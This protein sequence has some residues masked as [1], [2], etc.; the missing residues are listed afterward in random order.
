M[1]DVPIVDA[2]HHLCRLGM[3]YPWLSGAPT[4]RYHGDDTVLRHDYLVPDYLRDFGDLP[5]AAS[6][7][8][9]NGAGDPLEEARWIDGVCGRR[10]RPMVQVAKA[11]L[12]DPAAGEMLDA[13][14]DLLS[15]RGVRDIL[16][17]HPDPFYTHTARPHI[18][19]DPA[20]R[21]RFGELSGRGLSFDMQVFSRQLPEVTALAREFGDTSIVLDHLG[22]PVDRSAETLSQWAADMREL[23]G[24]PNVAVKISAMGTTDHHWT[25]GSIRPLVLTVIDAFGTDRC[26]FASNFPVDGMYTTLATLYGAFDQI[27]A[28]MS[29]DDRALLFGRTARAVYRIPEAEPPADGRSGA[30]AQDLTDSGSEERP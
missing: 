12:S 11:D 27:T 7:A 6:V 2:H 4:A 20:W 9:E 1:I 16:N 10:R 25:V 24:C 3:G 28:D 13:L 17:W 26:M 29:G 5:L 23:A 15:V 22:M 8:V 30:G 14:G 19:E 18:I 21:R